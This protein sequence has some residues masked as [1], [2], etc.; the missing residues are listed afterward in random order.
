VR[1]SLSRGQRIPEFRAISEL[2]IVRLFRVFTHSCVV[3]KLRHVSVALGVTAL[4]A[5]AGCGGDAKPFGVEPGTPPTLK[6][7]SMTEKPAEPAGFDE[8]GL[9]EPAEVASAVGVDAMYVIGRAV[10]TLLPE[11]GDYRVV[12]KYFPEDV[13]GL[14]GMDLSTVTNTSPEAF[15]TFAENYENVET[16][17]NLG[18]RAEAVAYRAN[19]SATHFVEVKTIKGNQGLHLLYVYRDGGL[20]PKADG[21]AAA[22]I[23]TKALERLPDEVTIPDG[24]PE[25]PCA[26]IDLSAAAEVV[27]DELTMARSV[28]AAKGAMNCYFSGTDANL[29]VVL[30]TEP[31]RVELSAVP[32]D[33]IT[34]ADLGDGARL[35]IGEDGRLH[36][37]VNMGDRLVRVAVDYGDDAGTV[38]EPRP[39]DVELVASIV[40]TFGAGD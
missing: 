21:A 11:F 38:T 37:V 1:Y 23:L 36:A 29:D 30:V 8:C 13:P 32:S 26:D 25:G 31:S 5:V 16:I 4:L 14:L 35:I 33:E 39:A 24:K 7:M 22:V 20:M 10:M 12:C 17:P 40:D 15:F 28:M 19:D 3:K 18:D 9:V 27:G 6:T 34:H 2:F